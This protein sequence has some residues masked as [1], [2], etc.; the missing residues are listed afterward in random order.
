MFIN[1]TFLSLKD[2]IFEKFNQLHPDEEAQLELLLSLPTPP[3]SEEWSGFIMAALEIGSD[4][5]CL[6]SHFAEMAIEVCTKEEIA[7][8]REYE[9][10]D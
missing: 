6:N 7:W 2:E 10:L 8:L 9:F 1:T 3:H 5:N 4:S